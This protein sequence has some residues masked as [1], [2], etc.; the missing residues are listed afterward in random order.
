M[1]ETP[2]ISR[3]LLM[4]LPKIFPIAISV[5]PLNAEKIFTVN[6]GADVPK[7][8]MVK[9]TTISEIPNF[10]AIADAPST[11]QLALNNIKVIPPNRNKIFTMILNLAAEII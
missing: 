5:A 2:S 3:I 9:P 1:A 11:N 6:S 4:L 10:F 7:A 8:T